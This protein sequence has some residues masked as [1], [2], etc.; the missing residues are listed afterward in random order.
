M[1]DGENPPRGSGTVP[2]AGD[3]GDELFSGGPA[4]DQAWW[5]G[6]FAAAP[7]E[8]KDAP[9][10]GDSAAELLAGLNPEQRAACLHR[11]GPLLILAG[12]GSGKTRVITHRLAHL[13]LGG[14]A[15]PHEILA[16]TF[17][18]KA[19]REMRERVERLLPGVGGAWIATFHALC[20]RI[21]RRD[22]E[23]L[24]AAGGPAYGRDFSIFDTADRNGL[25]KRIVK[26]LGF[27]AQRFRPSAIGAWI[28][29]RKNKAAGEGLSVVPD[30]RSGMD[31][32]VYARVL[33]RYEESMRAQNAL[34]F[35][36]LLLVVLELFEREPGVRDAYARRFRYVM[37]DE[38]QDTN[39]VQYLLARH[40]ASRHGNLAVCGDPDQ[41]IYA[42]RGAD[43]RNILDFE[44]DYPAARTV[45]LERNYR[46]TATILEAASGLIAHNR[47]RHDKALVAQGGR[48]EPLCVL[49]CSDENDEA[50]E[51]AL[52]C[53]GLRA[54]GRRLSEVAIL[55]R[56]NFM[57]RAL[58]TALRL[59]KVPYQVVAGLEF[60]ARRE[61]K[62]LLAYLRLA[63]N[64]ADDVAFARVVNA[65]GRGVGEASLARLAEWARERRVPLLA[66]AGEGEALA[67]IRGRAKKGLA[68]FAELVARLAPAA[69]VDAEVAIDL[70]LEEIDV[71]AWLGAM[72]DES[73]GVD[74][75]ANVSELRAH[76]AAYSAQNPGR[77]LRGFLEEI[78]LVSEAD[79]LEEGQDGVR[80]MTLHACKG[81]EFPFVFICGLEEELLP[82]ARSLDPEDDDAGLE[83][84]R[85]LLYVG[86]TRAKER[87]FLTHA[88]LRNFFGADRW[89][90][91]SRF[92][93]ELP[94]HLIEGGTAEAREPELQDLQLDPKSGLAVGARVE[95]DHFG[96][97]RVERLSGTGVNARAVV[98]FAHHGSKE[99]LLC[100]AKLRRIS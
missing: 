27:D 49:E 62:D 12:P 64:P 29:E 16:I 70:V 39:R 43:I 88:S 33:L 13:V 97:G 72:D 51:V 10:G 95:H 3:G 19:A 63:V 96:P 38:Y 9:G 44:A 34:D 78:A 37:V 68:Q 73:A 24:R 15:A 58:E 36:D 82:H 71:G 2:Q 45:R 79:G 59:A 26:E 54:R 42:W 83:E 48:G 77:G 18:N 1:V 90:L 67:S 91:R 92:L 100:Y 8:R 40:L 7:I 56:M 76:A 65:P 85:R 57:Q 80:L 17:T 6:A 22:V 32:E 35:D 93:D 30:H 5:P 75:E 23:A 55:Y 86:I 20:A 41:S 46:S 98:A 14:W 99:L 11:D 50:R 87:V 25:I 47:A 52:Q 66:A 61:I 4:G 31:E 21:L 69:E 28:S 60:Y 84:E 53:A 74:R 94:P 81:L 89:A